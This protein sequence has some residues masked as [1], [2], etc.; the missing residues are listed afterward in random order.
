MTPKPDSQ[1]RTIWD[2]EKTW[3]RLG[4]IP[5]LANRIAEGVRALFAR[6]GHV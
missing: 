4:L 1:N 5:C 2:Y 6:L 3:G